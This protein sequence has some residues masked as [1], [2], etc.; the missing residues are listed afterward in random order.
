ML[1]IKSLIVLFISYTSLASPLV[2]QP[3]CELHDCYDVN[4]VQ[5]ISIDSY[6]S[7][8]K[9][10]KNIKPIIHM[11]SPLD[12]FFCNDHVDNTMVGALGIRNSNALPTLNNIVVNFIPAISCIGTAYEPYLVN[13][14]NKAINISTN[15]MHLGIKTVVLYSISGTYNT[16][17]KINAM[18]KLTEIKGT[19]V[20]AA[21]GNN[22]MQYDNCKNKLFKGA[23]KLIIVGG[24]NTKGNG[25]LGTGMV[26][27][28]ARYYAP[29][30][31][32]SPI[33]GKRIVGTSFSSPIVS[34][35]ITNYLIKNKCDC[36]CDCSITDIFAFLD[37]KSTEI[38][39]KSK[40]GINVKMRF[41]KLN[42]I[43]KL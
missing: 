10:M 23:P 39:R 2:K 9:F 32:V 26:G 13:A 14:I 40:Q 29:G 4:K 24:T 20:V 12:N 19:Y 43:C 1:L 41:F 31:Y 33:S 34:Y 36:D 5:L 42:G 7:N 15:N 27:E 3:V 21:I 11:V 25:L 38:V 22:E 30:N 17:E 8:K 18:K 37:S 35:L 6:P 16:E 28:C